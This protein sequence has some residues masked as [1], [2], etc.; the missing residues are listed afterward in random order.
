MSDD[1]IPT[2]SSTPAETL[3]SLRSHFMKF[4][5]PPDF[6]SCTFDTSHV[7]DSYAKVSPDITGR[8]SPPEKAFVRS[9]LQDFEDS[10]ISG[11]RSYFPESPDRKCTTSASATELDV[12]DI[13]ARTQHSGI[14]SG[15]QTDS[16]SCKV[17]ACHSKS[18]LAAHKCHRENPHAPPSC[19]NQI[20]C[21][22][23]GPRGCR[24]SD[25]QRVQAMRILIFLCGPVAL[26]SL[27]SVAWVFIA[28]IIAALECKTCTCTQ[29]SYAQRTFRLLQV[30]IMIQLRCLDRRPSPQ[31]DCACFRD[32]NKL[33]IV[34]LVSPLLS[35]G[36]IIAAWVI[37]CYWA[38]ADIVGDP[39]GSNEKY[40]DGEDY[41]LLLRGWWAG[42]LCYG[43]HSC[44]AGSQM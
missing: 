15:R 3:W 12:A 6:S 44:D 28:T 33:V 13:V 35:I 17:Q 30:S 34:H 5:I 10:E 19:V 26:L 40:D 32:P 36:I 16:I 42:F 9:G 18:L 11:E 39:T 37:A 1:P 23:A 4:S 24:G 41:V 31:H 29:F 25:F 43:L 21:S 7:S 20:A 2:A 27:V 38:M 14:S 22:D 8:P